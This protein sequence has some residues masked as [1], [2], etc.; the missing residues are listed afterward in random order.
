MNFLDIFYKNPQISDFI[1]IRNAEA[2][3]F[4]ANR[5]AGTQE[6]MANLAVSFRNFAKA[7]K[8]YYNLSKKRELS[9]KG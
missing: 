4:H 1:K 2:E 7:S 9:C 3:L 8:N 5:Q 6:G